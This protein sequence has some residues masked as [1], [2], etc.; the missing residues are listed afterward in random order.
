MRKIRV[1]LYQKSLGI[2]ITKKDIR[3]I[4]DYSPHFVCFPEYFFVNRRLGNTL[5]TAH[6]E[7]WQVKRIEL[8]SKALNTVI[9]GGSMPELA[10]EVVYNTTHVYQNGVRLGSY[11]KKNLFY[12]EL[13]KITPGNEYK[14]FRAYGLTFGVLICADVFHDESFL[15]MKKNH[16]S[17]IFSPT[18]SLYKEET[19]QEKFRRDM[20]IY[21]RGARLADS[22]IVKVCGV[23]SDYRTYLQAR[24]LIA[25]RN[26]VL[27]R[28]LPEEEHTEMI[29]KREITLN[30]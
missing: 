9:I 26:E 16:A 21:V 12:T 6:N 24:S 28:V 14:T 8:L 10:D 3:E 13:G 20:D 1:I 7:A 2:S 18:F 22:V 5:Q 11:R 25:D 30:E 4:R 27:Y 23:R 15:F 19:I 29:I 17:I